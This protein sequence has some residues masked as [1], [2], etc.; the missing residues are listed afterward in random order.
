MPRGNRLRGDG[1]VFRLTHRCHNRAF[2][3]KFPVG[4]SGFVKRIQPLIL[5]RQETEIA[6]PAEGLWV[7]REP[8][9]PYVTETSPKSQPKR[10]L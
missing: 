7:L 6:E 10:G 2:L 3:L 8:A 5:S 9:I 4:S 1:G